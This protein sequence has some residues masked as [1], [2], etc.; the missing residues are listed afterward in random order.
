MRIK[1]N[2]N[3][4]GGRGGGYDFLN[5]ITERKE[6]N[7]PFLYIFDDILNIFK[8]EE[9]KNKFNEINKIWK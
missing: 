9:Y 7:I 5:K 2:E 8:K 3:T 1:G 6:G 4:F